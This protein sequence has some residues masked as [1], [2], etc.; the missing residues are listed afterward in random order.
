MTVHFHKISYVF[1]LSLY[2]YCMHETFFC[3]WIHVNGARFKTPP[4][5]FI[6]PVI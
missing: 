4:D 1:L 2:E 3:M 6:Q 5:C